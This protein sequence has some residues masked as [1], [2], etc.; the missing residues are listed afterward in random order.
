MGLAAVISYFQ[1]GGFSQSEPSH[2]G[3]LDIL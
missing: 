1:E 3:P 2:L